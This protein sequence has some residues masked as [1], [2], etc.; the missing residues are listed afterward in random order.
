MKHLFFD[1]DRTLWDF[2]KN[3]EKA[4]H[5]LFH[6]LGLDNDI[7]SFESFHALYKDKNAQLWKLYGSGKMSKQDLRSG[8]FRITLESFGVQDE[9]IIEKI[10]QGYIDISPRQ[11]ELFPGAIETLQELKEKGYLM[12]IITNG[13]K[14]VQ[15]IKLEN[16]NLSDFFK[17]IVCSEEV[18]KN[19]PAPDIFHHAMGLAG[20]R[21]DRSLMI[22]DDLDVDIIGANNAGM[23]GI[24][25]DPHDHYT[26]EEN[27][28]KIKSLPQL[29]ELIPVLL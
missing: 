7:P 16:S 2:E 23:K 15:Y 21:A 13:F 18:G 22:G 19:K 24:L 8:R 20:A 25:F 3:S 12:H 9:S 27:I 17:I 5:I 1:L 11:T 28:V 26:L 6:E 10:S 29:T 14:E 4:L